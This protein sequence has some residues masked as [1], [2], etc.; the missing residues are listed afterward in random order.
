VEV[1]MCEMVPT[2]MDNA[3]GTSFLGSI[4][5]TDNAFFSG[6]VGL[7]VIGALAQAARRGASLATLLARRHLLMTL[8]VTSKDASYPW[9]LAWLTKQ[10]RRTQH[11][12]VSTTQQHMNDGSV[13]YN[14]QKVAMIM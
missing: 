14:F 7:A 10:G 4:L 11:L 12:T 9:I 6:G 8:E 2:V 1:T 5:P 13:S 3:G